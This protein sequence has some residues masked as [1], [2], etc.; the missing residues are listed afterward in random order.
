MM[1]IDR[2][3]PWVIEEDERRNANREQGYRRSKKQPLRA[4]RRKIK[5]NGGKC[6]MSHRKAPY[7]GLQT[8]AQ[9]R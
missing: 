3:R 2:S 4:R 7:S 6:G 5:A 1:K 8:L 9:R